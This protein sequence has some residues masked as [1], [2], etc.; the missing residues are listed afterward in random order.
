MTCKAGYPCGLALPIQ[1]HLVVVEGL[2]PVI[3]P[4]NMQQIKFILKRE[5][6]SGNL[7][8]IRV[9]LAGFE[10]TIF[11]RKQRVTVPTGFSNR[12]RTS[13]SYFASPTTGCILLEPVVIPT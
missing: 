11:T 6:G 2:V 9:G 8:W 12:S 1:S 13:S 7:E 3:Q 4:Y 5:E 10:P